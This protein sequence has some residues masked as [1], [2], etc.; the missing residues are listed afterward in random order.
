MWSGQK[1]CSN[2]MIGRNEKDLESLPTY[3]TVEVGEKVAGI[4]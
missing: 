2:C 1:A 4:W 3:E